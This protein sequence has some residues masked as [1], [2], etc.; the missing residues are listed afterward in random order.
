VATLSSINGRRI[1][2]AYNARGHRKTIRLGRL[3]L[4]DA[5]AIRSHV[6]HLESAAISNLP[7]PLETSRWLAGIGAELHQKL[8]KAG[9]A[10]ARGQQLSLKLSEYF[11]AYVAKRTDLKPRSRTNL[12]QSR[13]NLVGYFGA[14]RDMTSITRGDVQDW[15]RT[16]SETF[17]AAT[18]SMF[19]KKARQVFTDAVDRKLLAD[20]PFRAVKAGD[21]SNA[22]RQRYVS[23]ADV[24]KVIRACPDHE[25]RLLFA[26]A[27]FAGLR[28]PSEI[29]TL[30]WTDVLWDESRMIVHSPKTERH[31]GKARRTV[32]IFP[33]LLSHLL[34]AQQLAEPGARH[35]FVRRRGENL[36]TTGNRI[37]ERAGLDPWPKTFQN[38]RSSCETDLVARFPLHVACIWIGNTAGIAVKHYLQVTEED[39]QRAAKSAVDRSGQARTE[40]GHAAQNPQ[41]NPESDES[42]YPLGESNPSEDSTRFLGKYHRAL[43]KALHSV[44]CY[45][46]H[47]SRVR[48]GGV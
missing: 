46:R 35:V 37:I 33:E 42:H 43:Q 44:N 4:N 45:A 18:V 9:L 14:A 6:A 17:A 7:V 39:Y 2:Q 1:V 24:H 12:Q 11:D 21:M 26:L 40:T 22:D 30:K 15:H 3:S 48:G 8:V 16:Q 34:E 25:W 19:V 28:V 27:R 31:K 41:E 38:L 5:R 47:L 20:N 23:A 36:A 13:N 10:V 29:R 32:P